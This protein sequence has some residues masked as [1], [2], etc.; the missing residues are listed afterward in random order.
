MHF[1]GHELERLTPGMRMGQG[2][3]MGA[4]QNVLERARTNW[5]E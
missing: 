2:V 4:N 5:E 3:R 1:Y